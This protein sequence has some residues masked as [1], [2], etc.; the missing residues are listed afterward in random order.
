MTVRSATLREL[1]RLDSV[2][3]VEGQAALRL[4]EALDSGKSIMAAA[5]NE[6][7]LLVTL[8]ELRRRKPAVKSKLEELRER[9]AGSQSA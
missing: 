9:R 6:R 7:Q 1:K 5:G 4:A 3:S 8:D 2:D